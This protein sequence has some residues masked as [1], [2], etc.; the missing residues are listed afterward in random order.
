M[1]HIIVIDEVDM[2]LEMGFNN[3]LNAILKNLPTERQTLIFSATLTNKIH[4]LAKLSLNVYIIF[5]LQ[6]LNFLIRNQNIFLYTKQKII[7]MKKM[8]QI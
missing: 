8:A 2:I 6:E 3:T 1:T 5:E 7:L 4:D